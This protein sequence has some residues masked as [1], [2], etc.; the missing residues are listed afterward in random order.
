MSHFNAGTHNMVVL[1][2]DHCPTPLSYMLEYEADRLG[3]TWFTVG[4]AAT[5]RALRA[6]V[7]GLRA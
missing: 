1:R 7:N 4:D 2:R 6:Y 5:I 3:N